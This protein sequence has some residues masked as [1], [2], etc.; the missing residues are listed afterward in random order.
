MALAEGLGKEG[1]RGRASM[2]GWAILEEWRSGDEPAQD[3]REGK[4]AAGD[5]PKP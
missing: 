5:Q 4:P 3:D 1:I 2:S